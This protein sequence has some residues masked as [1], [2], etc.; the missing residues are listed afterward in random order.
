MKILN[1]QI[2]LAATDLSNYLACRHLTN[3][4][5]QVAR[6]ERAEPAWAAPDLATLRELGLR[7][8]VAYLKFLSEQ[9]EL[10]VTNL[11]AQKNESELLSQT[12]RLMQEGAAVIAQGALR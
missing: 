5:L 9:Q 10:C 1:G 12:H 2:R 8:E 3:L 4:D 7:H 11:A 6:G